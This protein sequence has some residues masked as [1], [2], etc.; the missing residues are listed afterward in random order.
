MIERADGLDL[1]D[2][3]GK[4]RGAGAGFVVG[5][6]HGAVG[7]IHG[8]VPRFVNWELVRGLSGSLVTC[9]SLLRLCD[10]ACYPVTVVRE[11]EDLEVVVAGNTMYELLG[12]ELL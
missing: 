12:K 5:G 7:G 8:C 1:V 2:D 10:C 6:I 3:V 9:G 4:G 11:V